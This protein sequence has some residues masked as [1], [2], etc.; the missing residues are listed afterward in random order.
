[1]ELTRS[2]SAD[3]H[4]LRIVNELEIATETPNRVTWRLVGNP[5]ISG[6][7]PNSP[8]LGQNSIG[9]TFS[10]LGAYLDSGWTFSQ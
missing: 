9:G 1:M 10:A 2:P 8:S 4:W 5:E 3:D 7:L 6:S